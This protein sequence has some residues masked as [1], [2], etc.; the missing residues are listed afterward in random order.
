M[1]TIDNVIKNWTDRV[2]YC[3]ASRSMTG[4]IVLSN[5]KRTLRKYSVVFVSIFPKKKK[6]FGG[7][8][9]WKTIPSKIS[10]CNSKASVHKHIFSDYYNVYKSLTQHII[11]KKKEKINLCSSFVSLYSW[12]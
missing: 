2:S 8:C 9:N 7:P 12:I 11:Q 6:L 5:K 1:H 3:M 4:R 10:L